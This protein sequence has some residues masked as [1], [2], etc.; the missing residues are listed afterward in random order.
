LAN[1]A[2]IA[3]AKAKAVADDRD[4]YWKLTFYDC[5]YCDYNNRLQLNIGYCNKHL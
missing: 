4:S 2:E 3:M 5:K 1:A